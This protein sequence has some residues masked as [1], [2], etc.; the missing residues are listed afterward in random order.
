[1]EADEKHIRVSQREFMETERRYRDGLCRW[2]GYY[3][4]VPR[5]R[6]VVETYHITMY[7]LAPNEVISCNY[8]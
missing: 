3:V 2:G 5:T 8:E 6:T 1:V 7:T 4:A